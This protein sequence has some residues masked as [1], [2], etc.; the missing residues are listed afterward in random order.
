MSPFN[1]FHKYTKKKQVL[2]PE[3]LET[4]FLVV[5]GQSRPDL[6]VSNTPEHLLLAP[7][8]NRLCIRS[9]EYS[10]SG[11]FILTHPDVV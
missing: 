4:I 5:L 9:L 2:L 10:P 6:A 8:I 7:S 3:Y 1:D 11:K